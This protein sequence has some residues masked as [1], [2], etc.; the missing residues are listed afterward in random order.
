MENLAS[1][2]A[3]LEGNL[4]NWSFVG[5]KL[6]KQEQAG[7]IYP[8]VWS[9]PNFDRGPDKSPDNYAHELGRE[10]YA[11]LTETALDDTDVSVEFKQP[12]GAV[13]HGGI[14][15]R[16]QDSARF[17]VVDVNGLGRKG[18]F[19]ELVLWLQ[20]ADG[21]R[22][23]LARAMTPHS[24]VSN[25]IVQGGPKSR[26]QWDASSPDWVC[27]R[28][29]ATGQYMRLSV[30]G[31][32]LFDI[33]D[34]K[35]PTGYVGLMA[36]GAVY[37]RNFRVNGNPAET[38]QSFHSHEGE[39]P[40]FFYPGEVQPYGFNAWPTMCR[41]ES[42]ATI[43][44]WT[45][46]EVADGNGRRTHSIVVARSEDNGATWT[47]PATVYESPDGLVC[48]T[49]SLYAHRGYDDPRSVGGNQHGAISCL[50]SVEGPGLGN[51][52]NPVF[53]RSQD[54]GSTWNTE[55]ELM[56]AGRS[57]P[58]YTNAYSPMRRLSDGTVVMT[59]YEARPAPGTEG[60]TNA[61]RVDRAMLLRSKD[62]GYT[63]AE[64]IYFDETNYD[65]NECMVVEVEKGKLV[66]FMRTLR[67]STMW[68]SRSEDFGRSWT[69]LEASNVSG[70][71]PFLI[72][73]SSG[74]LIMFN[75]GNGSFIKLSSDGGETWSKEYR[76]SPCSA[77]I[78]MTELDDGSVMIIMHEGFRTPG[79]VRGQVF[80]IVADDSA[81]AAPEALVPRA[82]ALETR[83]V[84]HNYEQPDLSS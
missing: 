70:E 27:I 58:K 62:D 8:P 48:Y 10:D 30:D 59:A 37:F 1:I 17:Y 80:R 24:I 78:G 54:G 83:M 32:V 63:F 47:R 49:T 25:R 12:Y 9:Y 44:C 38:P 56:V 51:R 73:H 22:R 28:V 15:F 29:E 66:A 74:M 19:Y 71:C 35:Y 31:K 64:A 23:E 68:T 84:P 26:T 50:V 82:V 57:L 42:G 3:H 5:K 61:E 11:F 36:R 46:A 52:R 60:R 55:E 6:W 69:P 79:Y 72:R 75:R 43:V 16:A 77:M 65:H 34:G 40:A 53:V 41:T 20:D 81:A 67:A 18:A 4:Q 13:L 45:H 39:L 7:I 33:R 76:L 14:V 2:N 21:F